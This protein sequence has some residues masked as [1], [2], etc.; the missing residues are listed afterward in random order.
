MPYISAE[1][2]T[3][4]ILKKIADGDESVF[5]DVSD[6]DFNWFCG[7][8]RLFSSCAHTRHAK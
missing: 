1:E 7:V 3:S 5:S 6:N 8:G 2:F 4:P